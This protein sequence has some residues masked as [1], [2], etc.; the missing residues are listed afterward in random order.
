[1]RRRIIPVTPKTLE[2]SGLKCWSCTH[3]ETAD[4]VAAGQGQNIKAKQLRRIIKAS[5]ECGK[6]VCVGDKVLAYSQYGPAEFWQGTKRFSSGPVSS[7][8]ILLTCLYV[9][10]YAQGN[11]LGRV[12]LQS[13]EASLVKRRVRAIEV[14]ATRRDEHPPGPIEFYLQN[15]FYILRDDPQFPLLRLELKTLV[16]W[17]INI[18]FALDG[19]KIPARVRSGALA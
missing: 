17:Q 7:D 18:Q 4:S 16:G 10:P 12:L 13:I 8:A 19:L 1:M 14:F 3:W 11:G 9:L 5:G 6:L 2:R 15:G